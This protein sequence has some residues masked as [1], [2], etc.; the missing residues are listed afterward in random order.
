ML[1][2]LCRQAAVWVRVA[3]CGAV[4]FSRSNRPCRLRPRLRRSLAQC[5]LG[6]SE[7]RQTKSVRAWV[8]LDILL[9]DDTFRP[10]F[11]AFYL[12]EP[13]SNTFVIN[14][15][16]KKL[17]L[18]F[19]M[20]I[21]YFKCGQFNSSNS[22]AHKLYIRNWSQNYCPKTKFKSNLYD[23]KIFIKYENWPPINIDIQKF[24]PF[25]QVL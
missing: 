4:V 6:W 24:L 13:N 22:Y 25:L 18:H 12:P 8:A 15:L 5:I 16:F 3:F 10:F 7:M 21:K 20:R 11:L 19:K 1:R 23:K 14:M 9:Y 17:R 2:C